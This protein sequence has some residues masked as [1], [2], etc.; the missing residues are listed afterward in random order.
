MVLCI[1][2]T[3]CYVIIPGSSKKQPSYKVEHHRRYVT[4]VPQFNDVY[5]E[6]CVWRPSKKT[7][8]SIS[9]HGCSA[10]SKHNIEKVEVCAGNVYT[11]GCMWLFVEPGI[12][13]YICMF[14]YVH[15]IYP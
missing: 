12:Y 7:A 11:C 9:V 8:I 3:Y 5:S 6:L 10:T 1:V 13:I 2:H 14:H 15:I 4:P